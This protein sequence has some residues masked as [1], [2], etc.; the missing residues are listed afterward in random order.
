M[1]PVVLSST[2]AV[3]AVL[4]V[5]AELSEL[6]LAFWIWMSDWLD[7]LDDED[8]AVLLWAAV[9]LDSLLDDD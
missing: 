6:L 2:L 4:E 7:F 9:L 1:T 3:L 8:L 5:V